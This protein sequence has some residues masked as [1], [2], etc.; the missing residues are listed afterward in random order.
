MLLQKH[1]TVLVLGQSYVCRLHDHLDATGQVNFNL[2]PVGHSVHF[3]GISGL[4]FPMLIRKFPRLIRKLPSLCEAGYDLVLLDF[5]PNNLAAG[6]SPDIMVD[7]TMSVA[8]IC[9]RVVQDARAGV[10]PELWGIVGWYGDEGCGA[11][12]GSIHQ[13]RRPLHHHALWR[14]RQDIQPSLQLAGVWRHGYAE[15]GMHQP[16]RQ[17][18]WHSAAQVGRVREEGQSP[19]E[20]GATASWNRP[21]STS[22]WRTT[23]RQ[24]VTTRTASVVCRVPSWRHSNMPSRQTTTRSTSS[25]NAT[26]RHRWRYKRSL[27]SFLGISFNDAVQKGRR[28]VS[29]LWKAY[30]GA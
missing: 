16:R 4:Q 30:C 6:C 9:Y 10:Q 15:G 22:W 2:Q 5:R 3:R 27:P 11:T 29:E 20:V 19:L 21:P 12:V 8:E 28:F 14:R 26:R 1:G 24:C 25:R 17:T 7:M 18:T 23:A 13:P